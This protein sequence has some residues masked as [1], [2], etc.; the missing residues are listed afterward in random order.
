MLTLKA[1]R[2][3]VVELRSKVAEKDGSGWSL[4]HNQ[5]D[6]GCFETAYFL[7]KECGFVV[8]QLACRLLVSC[9][10][11]EPVY[12]YVSLLR[13]C[14]ARCVQ[15][16]F[17]PFGENSETLFHY[18]A[19]ATPPNCEAVSV[20]LQFPGVAL[21][22]QNKRGNSEL[23][24]AVMQNATSLVKVLVS[25]GQ[26]PSTKSKSGQSALDIATS[27]KLKEMCNVLAEKPPSDSVFFAPGD[28]SDTHLS[29]PRGYSEFQRVFVE[30]RTP[31]FSFYSEEAMSLVVLSAQN[32][33]NGS[34][35]VK[36]EKD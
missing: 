3:R 33:A 21:G 9:P 22:W 25:A 34:L 7:V 2:N 19:M 6:S 30:K 8:D 28:N 14:L 4:L 18:A 20:M 11:R 13:D 32:D 36:Y 26:D 1:A 16:P 17:V 12:L 15:S 27:L 24:I 31:Y 29:M 35:F 5:L 10:V 23:H